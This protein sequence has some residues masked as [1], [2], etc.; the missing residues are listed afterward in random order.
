M[1]LL[2][3]NRRVHTE[4]STI[5][6]LLVDGKFQCFTLED[7]DR[8]LERGGKKIQ[9][10][11]AIPRGKY[12]VQI[13]FSQRFQKYL[14]LVVGVAQFEGVRIHSGNTD[15]DTEGCIL[16]GSSFGVDVIHDSRA[17]FNVLFDRMDDVI[18]KQHSTIL[19][20]VM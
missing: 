20:E 10:V 1:M 17:A 14:P 5:G 16:V 2:T 18:N 6:E 11:T 7:C 4:K 9:N 13:T 12:N 15:K 19:L 8:Y 3:L